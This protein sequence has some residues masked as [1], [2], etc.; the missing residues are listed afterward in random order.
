[1]VWIYMCS[2]S[3]GWPP[4]SLQWLRT[5]ASPCPWTKCVL[6]LLAAAN[7]H[8]EVLQWV[9]HSGVLH[10]KLVA[11]TC[12]SGLGAKI[13][14]VPETRKSILQQKGTGMM[15]IQGGHCCTDVLSM[16]VLG[17]RMSA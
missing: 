16:K 10:V 13:L 15:I 3:C 1:M 4:E 12:C 14:P 2:S 9:M 6:L 17:N 5:Q 7:S 8:L 11:Y